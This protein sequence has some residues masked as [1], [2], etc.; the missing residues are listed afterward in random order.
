MHVVGLRQ[1]DAL[2]KCSKLVLGGVDLEGKSRKSDVPKGD[3][4][5]GAFFSSTPLLELRP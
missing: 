2:L 3:I 5:P 1:E 4:F